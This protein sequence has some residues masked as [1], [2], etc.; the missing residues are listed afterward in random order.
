MTETFTTQTLVLAH[1]E[2]A[3]QSTGGVEIR[4]QT[5][6]P[7]EPRGAVLFV[8][9]LAEHS[10][11]YGYPID[12]FA[13]HGFQCSALDLRG[14]GR[15]EGRRVHV[16]RFSDYIYDVRTARNYLERRDPELPIFQVGHSMGGLITIL[17]VLDAPENLRAAAVSSPALGVPAAQEPGFLLKLIAAL[18]DRIA[19]RTLIPGI[20]GKAIS[21]DPAVV[22]AYFAD[23]LVSRK[24]TPRWFSQI[25]AAME[26][27]HRRAGELRSDLL[28][29]QSGAD[30]LVDPA[31]TARWVQEAPTAHVSWKLWDGLY[32]EM[33]NEPER[34]QV[35]EYLLAWIEA[36][37][38]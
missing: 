9:G 22:Q 26:E 24:V 20:D 15:S 6:R 16:D 5:W 2:D 1:R 4:M 31:A 34:D 29:M 28:V 11:R 23:P 14:H 27:A 7:Q 3:L 13:R 21:R 25:R 36:R 35:F 17:D 32:H 18:L 30:Q 37:L 33:F 8:H 12:F 38:P 19:P 10:G